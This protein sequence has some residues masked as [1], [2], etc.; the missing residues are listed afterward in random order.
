[1]TDRRSSWTQDE[2]DREIDRRIDRWKQELLDT[3][4]RNRMINYRE[5]KRS[6][7][8]ILEPEPEELFRLLAVSEKE[9]T[10]Q[11]P[12]SR[13]SDFR[14]YAV[15]ALLDALN[16]PLPVQRG[17]IRAAGTIGE[18]DQTLKNLRS[19]TK[20]AQEEQGINILYLSFGFLLWRE[21]NKP[22]TQWVKSPVLMMPVSLG[23]QSLNA[24]YTLKKYDDEIEVNP[25]LDHLFRQEYGVELPPFELR[26]KDSY[27]EYMAEIGRIADRRGW[28]LVQEV[29]LGLVSFLKIGMYHDLEEHRELIRQNAVLRAIAA[30][31]AGTSI[32]VPE[33][34]R[35]Y[36]FDGANPADWHEVVDADSSQ[37][38]AILLSKRG[39]S[40]VMQGPPG[41]G[42]SQTI[43]NIIA[44]ALADG[45][46]VLFVSEKA[47]ALQVVRKRLAEVGLADFCLSLH[48]Y[49]ANKK[50]IVHEIGANLT[51]ERRPEPWNALSDLTDLFHDRNHLNEY[52]GELHAAVEAAERD[53]RGLPDPE[54]GRCDTGTVP[55]HAVRGRR[56]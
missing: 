8:R 20:L 55:E 34:V 31:G 14:T 50:A 44:E 25:T 54:S 38:E 24:P 22:G 4:K 51:L 2:Y 16:Y 37:E 35:N 29:S 39:V 46:K 21:D 19:R 43:T 11:R 32:P 13:D 3:G 17:D 10:F 9:L 41:T 47:A 27:A 56:V 26:G 5:T 30:G 45:K 52:A 28:K 1:M 12:V 36:D 40:F 49:K 33:D 15:L 42:K 23:L 18:R 6:T 53:R 7:M 48:S